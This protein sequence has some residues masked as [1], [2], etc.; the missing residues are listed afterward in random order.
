MTQIPS[1]FLHRYRTKVSCPSLPHA[2]TCRS[3]SH[4]PHR[5]Q[6][7]TFIQGEAQ[8]RGVHTIEMLA[9]KGGPVTQ[10][11]IFGRFS[12]TFWSNFVRLKLLF[13]RP[14]S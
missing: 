11:V 7:M 3:A 14:V 8:R 12:V 4:T 1:I 13:S 2:V 5:L 6:V 9:I 10:V